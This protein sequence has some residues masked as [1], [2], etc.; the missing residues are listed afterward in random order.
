MHTDYFGLLRSEQYVLLFWMLRG[1]CTPWN[2]FFS[3]QLV[4]F[5]VYE[6][7]AFLHTGKMV[8]GKVADR[9]PLHSS[10]EPAIPL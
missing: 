7:Q 5:F 9:F 8:L 2:S 10:E 6:E 4:I 3:L 1:I